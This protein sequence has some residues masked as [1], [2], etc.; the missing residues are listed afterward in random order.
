M[1]FE[2]IFQIF[3][4]AK[5]NGAATQTGRKGMLMNVAGAVEVFIESLA[6][7]NSES[8]NTQ[9]SKLP[10]NLSAVHFKVFLG[11]KFH[12]SEISYQIISPVYLGTM[13][14]KTNSFDNKILNALTSLTYYF[15]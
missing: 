10:K 6:A 14:R 7:G 1:K 15:F 8:V 9:A 3:R 12:L 5:P 2:Y 11:L 13:F 4:H